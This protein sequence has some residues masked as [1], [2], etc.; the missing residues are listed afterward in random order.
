[1]A[2]A[3][4]HVQDLRHRADV[5]RR[6][7]LEAAGVRA[8]SSPFAAHF[9]GRV[10][11]AKDAG[12]GW[13]ELRSSWEQGCRYDLLRNGASARELIRVLRRTGNMMGRLLSIDLIKQGVTVV[14]IHVRALIH[15]PRSSAS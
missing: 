5:P 3:R 12:R 14:D 13:G 6:E 7:A 8:R 1:M 2:G 15:H 9:R 10:D 11:R 4:R